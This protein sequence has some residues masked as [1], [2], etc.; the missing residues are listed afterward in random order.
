MTKTLRRYFNALNQQAAR[1]YA[2]KHPKEQKGSRVRILPGSPSLA[3]WCL[4]ISPCNLSVYLN[5]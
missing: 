5:K 2:A 4:G 3:P 1:E